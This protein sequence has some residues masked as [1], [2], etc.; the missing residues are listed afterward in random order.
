MVQT[1]QNGWDPFLCTVKPPLNGQHSTANERPRYDEIA[2]TPLLHIMDRVR[3]PNSIHND[4][5]LVDTRQIFQQVGLPSLV[6]LTI[7]VVLL[8]ID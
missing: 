3:G 2:N 5:N 7:R 8:L 1:P 6:E 4:P